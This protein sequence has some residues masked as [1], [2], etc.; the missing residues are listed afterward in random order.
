MRKLNCTSSLFLPKS[1][2]IHFVFPIVHNQR[3]HR[4]AP[5]PCTPGVPGLSSST[6]EKEGRSGW[7]PGGAGSCTWCEAHGL[8]ASTIPLCTLHKG[9]LPR[10]SLLDEGITQRTLLSSCC[11]HQMKNYKGWFCQIQNFIQARTNWCDAV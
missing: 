4:H 2:L 6:G 1:R 10:Q 3:E 5:P 11:S 7:D 9:V 8:V